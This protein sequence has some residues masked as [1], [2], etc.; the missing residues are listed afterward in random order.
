MEKVW[1]NNDSTQSTPKIFSIEEIFDIVDR[2]SL[3][4]DAYITKLVIGGKS[5]TAYYSDGRSITNPIGN[6]IKQNPCIMA[7]MANRCPSFDEMGR[8]LAKI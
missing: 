2:P 8:I 7:I 6:E 5:V 1:T 4:S 3:V